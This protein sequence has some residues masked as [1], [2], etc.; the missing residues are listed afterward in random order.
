MY[1]YVPFKK[2]GKRGNSSSGEGMAI[3]NK[4]VM[5]HA[6]VKR[7]FCDDVHAGIAELKTYHGDIGLALICNIA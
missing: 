7:N 1:V 4:D 5:R 6:F 2:K 3:D